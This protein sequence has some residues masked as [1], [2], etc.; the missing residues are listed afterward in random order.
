MGAEMYYLKECIKE[1]CIITN[2]ITC[3]V[4]VCLKGWRSQRVLMYSMFIMFQC[5]RCVSPLWPT[6]EDVGLSGASGRRD[7]RARP[8]S[9]YE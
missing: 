1:K 8:D 5:E 2:H 3:A 4:C 9:W 7:D 6:A